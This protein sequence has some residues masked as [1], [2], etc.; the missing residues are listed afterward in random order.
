VT[1]VPKLAEGA[2]DAL[3][4]GD[5][6]GHDALAA[7]AARALVDCDAIALAQFSLARAAGRIERATGLRVLTTPQSAV[8]KLKR[9]LL[10]AGREGADQSLSS[11]RA[12]T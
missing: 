1:V 11:S 5:A 6:E 12:G 4:R 3:E 2:L 7:A 8:R 9:L 10:G